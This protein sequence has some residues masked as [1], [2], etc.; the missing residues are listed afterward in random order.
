MLKNTL[1]III[2]IVIFSCKNQPKKEEE[3]QDGF[4]K[5]S[6]QQFKSLGI[7]VDNP[8]NNIFN[9]AIK[10][11]GK[12]DVPPQNRAKVTSF[13]PGYVKETQLLIG[14]RVRKGQ[15][16]ISLES[17]GFLDIQKD[18][19]EVTNNIKYLKSEYER[20]KKLYEEQITSEKNYLKAESDYNMSKALQNSLKEKLKLMNISPENTEK[21]KLTSKIQIYSPISGDI[22]IMNVNVGMPIAASDVI[23]EIVDTQ[24][25]HLELA[26]FEKDILKI[27]KG[28]KI[29]FKVPEATKEVFEAEVFL[30]GKT[31]EGNSR[32]IQ[33]H[34]HLEDNIKQRLLTGMFV[35][36][37]II[38]SSKKGLGVPA[39][40]VV[41][42]NDK[43]FVLL[44]VDDKNGYSF[45]K[46][47]VDLG[48]RNE[49]FVE[50]IPNKDVNTTSKIVV[51]GIYDL[52][53]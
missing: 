43:N 21:G 48:E 26:V 34:G 29:E 8:K 41:T 53:E 5:I 25:L 9:I 28:Q 50:I 4:I 42:Q 22:A 31:I 51:K 24:H 32:T 13:V 36:A 45:K 38:T 52:V 6:E 7:E 15:V 20:Q 12:I 30:V 49:K 19:L 11:S 35:E 16:L 2:V 44:L 27:K 3:K 10:A 23:L 14:D 47:K 1:W 17:T 40:A 46:V 33:V 18:Y 37:S 39:D